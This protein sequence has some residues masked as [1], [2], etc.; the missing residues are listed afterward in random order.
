[1]RTH[2][3][4]V[5]CL[6]AGAGCLERTVPAAPPAPAVSTA[7][8]AIEAAAKMDARTPVPL[9]P[10]MA[11][12]QKQQ[13]RSHLGAVQEIVAALAKN[14]FAG[15]QAAS[16]KIGYSDSMAQMCTHMGAG[17]P[18]F[19]SLAIEFHRTADAIGAAATKKDRAGVL[20]ALNAT[21]NTCVGCHA[22]YKQQVVDETTWTRLTSMAPP[23]TT[24]PMHHQ[25]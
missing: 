11:E 9:L 15:V 10:M 18:G 6:V 1:M 17:A 2:V 24:G 19:S 7:P 14:D 4:M 12:H 8:S 21:L 5:A 23:A 25:P 22:I 3:L 20:A 16:T 13:M